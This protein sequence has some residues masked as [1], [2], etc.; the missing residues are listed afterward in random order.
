MRS[1]TTKTK[2]NNRKLFPKLMISATSDEFIVL[3]AKD[4]LGIIVQSS[5][6]NQIGDRYYGNATDKFI[7]YSGQVTLSND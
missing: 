1:I 3:F 7:D 2:D 4:D 6:K 5:Q